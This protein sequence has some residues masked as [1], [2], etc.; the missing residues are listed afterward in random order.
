MLPPEAG[1]IQDT[2]PQLSIIIPTLN[3]AAHLPALLAD[4]QQQQGLSLE[5]IVGDGG[6]T[7][8]TA[9]IADSF[10]ARLVHSGRG[11]GRQMN[12]AA[13]WAR[14][15]FLLFLHADSRLEEPLLLRTALTALQQAEREQPGIAGH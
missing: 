5:L 4:L 10:G 9:R 3:E 2:P 12:A 15:E 14:G 13:R 6:S 8:A 7:D 11:R 1:L